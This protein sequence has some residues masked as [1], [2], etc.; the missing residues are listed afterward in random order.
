MDTYSILLVVE[1]FVIAALSLYIWID[2]RDGEHVTTIHWIALFLL[3]L[4]LIGFGATFGLDPI[5][6]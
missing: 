3:V 4:V 2:T 1:A 5:A 6:M